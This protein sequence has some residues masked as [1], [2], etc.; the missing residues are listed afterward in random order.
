M[1][2]TTSS[3]MHPAFVQLSSEYIESLNVTCDAYEHKITG[4][5]HY[6][7]AAEKKENV[8]LVVRASISLVVPKI[9]SSI[10]S[11]T[12]LSIVFPPPEP[13]LRETFVAALLIKSGLQ[14]TNVAFDLPSDI[15][16][17]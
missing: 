12:I 16:L 7:L 4:A 1:A 9:S 5:K 2:S 14:H 11:L 3:E 8:F 13:N 17:A 10:S 15:I 6:H